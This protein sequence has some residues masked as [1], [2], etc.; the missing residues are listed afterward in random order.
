MVR[1]GTAPHPSLPSLPF[2]LSLS[3][4]GRK[5]TQAGIARA[6]FDRLRANGGLWLQVEWVCGFCAR[7]RWFGQARSP[8]PSLP[9]VLSLSKD[10]RKGTAGWPL[11]SALRQA[12]GERGLR[13]Q[14][15]R[16]VVSGQARSA[17]QCAQAAAGEGAEAELCAQGFELVGL[18][19]PA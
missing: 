9:F 8:H 11:A 7:V 5:G 2:V 18:A 4:D 13:L 14:S 12:Q 17:Q 10:G 15:E 16:A 1:S 3:K 6:P 19:G